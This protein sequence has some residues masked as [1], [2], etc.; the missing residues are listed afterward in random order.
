LIPHAGLGDQTVEAITN[1][2]S[3]PQSLWDAYKQSIRTA[4][5]AGKSGTAAARAMLSDLQLPSGA[6]KV[7]AVKAAK[8]YDLLF[9]DNASL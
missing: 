9:A 7:G 5:A 6:A 3:T 8:V 4:M 1:A 2:Y